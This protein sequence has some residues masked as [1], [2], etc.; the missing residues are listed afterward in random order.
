MSAHRER[1]CGLPAD[2]QPKRLAVYLRTISQKS[3][4]FRES[5]RVSAYHLTAFA[6]YLWQESQ[7]CPHIENGLRVSA[8]HLRVFAV[9]LWIISRNTFAV[10]LWRESQES[11]YHR[12][13]LCSLFV[14][15]KPRVSQHR[16]SF[17][18]VRTSAESLCGLPAI[19][20]PFTPCKAKYPLCGWAVMGL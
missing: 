19:I 18:S 3:P 17:A 16:E 13:S 11:P 15:R 6:I 8:H 7:E 1:L 12:E 5:D 2:Y 4:H 10:Y 9:S 14:A 20:A